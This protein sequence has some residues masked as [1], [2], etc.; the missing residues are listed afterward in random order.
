MESDI[1]TVPE[2]AEDVANKVA[3]LGPPQAEY[4]ITT[5]RFVKQL[6]AAF[7]LLP[8]GAVMMGLP[9]LMIWFQHGGHE[10]FLI[11]KLAVLGFIFLSGS[12][13]LAQR[14]YRNRG[15]RVLVYPEG[16]VRLHR[17]EA[18]TLFWD[19]AE[20]VWQKRPATA[21]ARLSQ[22]KLVFAVKRSDGTELV[23]DDSLPDVHRLGTTLHQHTLKHLL[24]RALAALDQG[25]SVAF[26]KLRATRR[27]LSNGRET[28]PWSQLRP[29]RVEAD[30][31]FIER[32]GAWL[33]WHNGSVSETPNFHVLQSLIRD[34]M[35]A[36]DAPKTSDG[37]PTH[38]EQS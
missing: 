34:R 4:A 7:L 5:R 2:S 11:F 25:Q 16:L 26:G 30:R 29:P 37:R 17:H 14:A 33:P 28:V 23:F 18:R 27:G 35:K 8:L 15:L 20:Q 12:V 6:L 1:W 21:W 32:Q 24:P 13:L 31:F 38:V 10:H 36:S 9:L 3:E 22:G 19:E